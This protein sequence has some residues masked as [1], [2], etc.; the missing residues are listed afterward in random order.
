MRKKILVTVLL[1]SLIITLSSS[2]NVIGVEDSREA[3]P[4]G[5]PH[6]FS[7]EIHPDGCFLQWEPP[8]YNGSIDIL[9]YRIFKNGSEDELGPFIIAELGPDTLNFTDNETINGFVY[10]YYITA[11]NE[12]GDSAR[13]GPIDL[14]PRGGATSPRD[15]ELTSG[16][17]SITVS[18]TPPL[19]D[20]G[21]DLLSNSIFR[22]REGKFDLLKEVGPF[23]HEYTDDTTIPGTKYSYYVVANSEFGP[24]QPS[25]E[26]YQYS[27]GLP[28]VPGNL[29][30]KE[31]C[32][33]ISIIWDINSKELDPYEIDT[34]NIYRNGIFFTSE[35]Y[36]NGS[37]DLLN[38]ENGV[39]E[40]VKI[41]F[42]NRYGEG[43]PT[44]ELFATPGCPPSI[45]MNVSVKADFRNLTVSWE[46][47]VSDGGFPISYYRIIVDGEELPHHFSYMAPSNRTQFKFDVYNE[48]DRTYEIKVYAVNE[49]GRSEDSN[50]AS[51]TIPSLR[52]PCTPGGVSLTLINSSSILIE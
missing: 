43:S 1:L 32:G 26:S 11:Y 47:S 10:Q 9:G 41:S 28:P 27:L 29:R 22:T 39:T 12:M 24:G 31:Y 15:L 49:R 8:G 21:Y 46:A 51:I 25:E 35:P 17:G 33:Y 36:L 52:K 6:E 23:I 3:S 44:R 50:V 48:Y 2:E 13:A 40:R 16:L 18:W 19:S 7:G 37:I 5:R 42:S 34:V 38:L 45:P 14:S 4:P 20:G 30:T